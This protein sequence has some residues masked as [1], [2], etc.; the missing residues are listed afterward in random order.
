MLLLS[1][2]YAIGLLFHMYVGCI[3]K[4]STHVNIPIIISFAKVNNRR[5]SGS[6]ISWTAT[7]A[8]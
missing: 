5:E 2:K 8:E 4:I 3:L 1:R 6:S 7:A